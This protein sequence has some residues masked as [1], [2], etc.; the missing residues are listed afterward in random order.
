MVKFGLVLIYISYH[1]KSYSI[2]WEKL[3]S[4]HYLHFSFEKHVPSQILKY[5]PVENLETTP[6]VFS[7][8]LAL[9]FICLKL[10]VTGLDFLHYT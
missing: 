7:Q 9:R 1:K 2:F 4:I 6:T 5:I 10:L 3:C 8:N